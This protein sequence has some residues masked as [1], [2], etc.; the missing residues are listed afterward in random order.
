VPSVASLRAALRAQADPVSAVQAQRFFQSGPGEYAEGDAFLGVRVPAV[1]AIVRANRSVALA[2]CVA[3]LESKWHEERLLALL[4]MVQLHQRGDRA[5]QL[6]VFNACL[7]NLRHIDNWDLVDTSVPQLIGPHVPADNLRLLETL[8]RSSS[9]W[10][11]RIA[12]LATFHHLRQREFEPTLRIATILLDDP[13]HLIHKAT[14]WMLREM[15]ERDL[16]RLVAFL[17]T[18]WRRM[19]RTAVRYAIEKFTPAQR[20]KYMR[21]SESP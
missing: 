8:A 7:A 9:L 2:T 14:G 6:A 16:P 20:R 18:H 10:E 1:R 13:H 5:Q 17:D 21:A 3:L 15:G 19:P 4:L 11:R 12:M